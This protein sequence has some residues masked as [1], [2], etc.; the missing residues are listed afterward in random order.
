MNDREWLWYS[1]GQV[2]VVLIC[3]IAAVAIYVGWIV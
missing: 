2:C 3:T 1:L